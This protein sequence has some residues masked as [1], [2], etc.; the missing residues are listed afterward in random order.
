M[1][2]REKRT[3]AACQNSIQSKL[4]GDYSMAGSAGNL[5][6]ALD[7]WGIPTLQI[8]LGRELHRHCKYLLLLP[9]SEKTGTLG[10]LHLLSKT[11]FC[12][13]GGRYGSKGD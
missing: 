11:Q 6:T 8:Q 7:A 9:A 10:G 5:T 2:S 12:T 13:A 1:R 3:H 4:T